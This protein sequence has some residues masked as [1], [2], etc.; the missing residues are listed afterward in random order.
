MVLSASAGVISSGDNVLVVAGTT[1][2]SMGTNP[3]LSTEAIMCSYDH[4]EKWGQRALTLF[5]PGYGAEAVCPQFTPLITGIIDLSPL[6]QCQSARPMSKQD[7]REI[8]L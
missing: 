5:R 2:A 1:S 7:A 4:V 6:H 3:T 8:S